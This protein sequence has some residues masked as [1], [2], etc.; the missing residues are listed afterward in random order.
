MRLPPNFFKQPAVNLAPLLLGKMLCRK[1][2]MEVV[3]FAITETEAYAGE[4][5]T[6]CHAHK[7]KTPR[8]TVMYGESGIAY[9]YLCYGIHHLLNVVAADVGEPEA[10]LIRG[11]GGIS[12]PGRLTKALQIDMKFNKTNLITSD[13]LWLEDGIQLPYI[14]TPRIG[15]GYASEEDKAQ[16][17]RFVAV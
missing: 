16:L 10:V 2:G 7:G 1:I 3:R 15:I 9:V 11:I 4:S 17:W 8:T 13:E 14:T 5:D 12:G 6:A